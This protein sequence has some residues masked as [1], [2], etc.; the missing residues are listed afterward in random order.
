MSQA[1]QP[2][3]KRSGRRLSRLED[4]LDKLTNHLR[5]LKAN[6]QEL[7]VKQLPRRPIVSTR[8]A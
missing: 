7:E 8:I 1:Q 3:H 2:N 5:D 4:R 6:Q